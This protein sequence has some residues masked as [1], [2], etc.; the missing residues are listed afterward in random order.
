MFTFL[1]IFLRPSLSS[2][3]SSFFFSFCF[4]HS[5]NQNLNNN[6]TQKLPKSKSLWIPHFQL[7]F[8]LRSKIKTWFSEYQISCSHNLIFIERW[9][10]RRWFFLDLI[11]LLLLILCCCWLDV[12][13]MIRR[14][15]RNYFAG[16]FS[17]SEFGEIV[18]CCCC[19]SWSVDDDENL[20][21]LIF[22]I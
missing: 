22:S 8:C 6:N 11:L 1:L 14:I 17:S 16:F 5:K 4:I 9:R 19:C 13:L 10:W 18:M 12:L 20:E 3:P 21:K 15:W 2:V 7:R